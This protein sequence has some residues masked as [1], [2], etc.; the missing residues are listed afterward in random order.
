MMKL[1]VFQKTNQLY[2]EL[3]CGC[4]LLCLVEEMLK[5]NLPFLIFE[6]KYRITVD[7]TLSL[8]IRLILS[9]ALR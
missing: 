4:I 7:L 8:S 6:D 5:L 3:C 2:Q 1:R 9:D